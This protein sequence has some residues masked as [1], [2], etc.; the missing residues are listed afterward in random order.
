MALEW[1]KWRADGVH[2]V[3]LEWEK[4]R[5]DGAHS[6]AST[7]LSKASVEGMCSFCILLTLSLSW[8]CTWYQYCSSDVYTCD[9]FFIDH[10]HGISTA[11]QTFT[12]VTGFSLIIHMVQNLQMGRK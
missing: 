10:S 2:S 6:V 5:A 12:H 8:M 11:V 1:G 3:A 9:R 7:F 4:L